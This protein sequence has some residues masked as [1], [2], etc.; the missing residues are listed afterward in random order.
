M[1][2]SN[3][4]LATALILGLTAMD[5]DPNRNWSEKRSADERD[6]ARR[7]SAH[8]VTMVPDMGELAVI[9]VGIWVQQMTHVLKENRDFYHGPDVFRENEHY[10]YAD[11]S[12]W[13]ED[14]EVEPPSWAERSGV[15]AL[16]E[17]FND[18]AVLELHRLH[19]RH[20]RQKAEA[21]QEKRRAKAEEKRA[22]Q[23]RAIRQGQ[24]VAQM[25]RSATA[26]T[27]GMMH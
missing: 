1:T 16:Q 14:S 12:G 6:A 9:C 22:E 23:Q 7:L 13:T 18:K 8:I 5:S 25:M 19:E 21:A 26:A 17:V 3:T 27:S 4:E 11:D 2:L 10:Q 20:K 15:A 24:V